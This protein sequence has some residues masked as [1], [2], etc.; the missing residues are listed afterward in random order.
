MYTAARCHRPSPAQP[1]TWRNVQC[2]KSALDPDNPVCDVLL[3]SLWWRWGSAQVSLSPAHCEDKIATPVQSTVNINSLL[4]SPRH[5][6][7]TISAYHHAVCWQCNMWYGS[8]V[9]WFQESS[10]DAG[11]VTSEVL[12]C[13]RIWVSQH[14]TTLSVRHQSWV[15][16]NKILYYTQDVMFQSGYYT[17]TEEKLTC[18]GLHTG[19]SVLPPPGAGGC[20]GAGAGRVWWL[21]MWPPSVLQS[22][23]G[24]HLAHCADVRTFQ[25]LQ[26]ICGYANEIWHRDSSKELWQ[27]T[28]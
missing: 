20:W 10:Q 17:G 25:W 1:S 14:H 24:G 28:R 7:I 16:R 22:R 19:S 4:I 26:N 13:V 3:T 12:W 5:F 9:G 18:D 27:I 23:R 6:T 2:A 21:A 11:S 15:M 8:S